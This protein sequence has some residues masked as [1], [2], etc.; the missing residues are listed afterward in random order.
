MN[1]ATKSKEHIRL[2]HSL[3]LQK[4]FHALCSL[5]FYYGEFSFCFD[6]LRF[7]KYKYKSEDYRSGIYQHIL[8]LYFSEGYN[9]KLMLIGNGE[10]HRDSYGDFITKENKGS[11]KDIMN[12]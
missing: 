11:I 9:P 4:K 6:Y 8:E 5:I 7:L 10:P 2:A 1:L 12:N 3:Y